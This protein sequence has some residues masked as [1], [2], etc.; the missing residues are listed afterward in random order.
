MGLQ[1]NFCDVRTAFEG[2]VWLSKW[3]WWLRGHR[4]SRLIPFSQMVVQACRAFRPSWI[5]SVGTAPVE[6]KALEAIGQMQ[7]VRLN[8]LTD[9]PWNPTHRAE[10]FM[11]ALPLYDRIYSTRRANLAKL[12]HLNHPQVHH[13]PF[14]YAPEIHFPE[15]PADSER[16][17]LS[18]EVLFVG[19]ADSD[20]LPWI[21]ALIRSGFRPALYGGYWGRFP[22]TRPY[23]KGY[24]DPQRLRRAVGQ[25]KVNL[26]LVRRANRDGHCMRSFEIPAMGG[27]MLTE[28]TEEHREIFGEE[29][30]TVSY[31]R[32][33]HQMIEKLR[34]LLKREDERKRLASAVHRLITGGRNTY[35]DRLE[36]LLATEHEKW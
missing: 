35:R 20:R 30:K 11:E 19:G 14:A 22:E 17:Q 2:S 15:L 16:E 4:P 5:L 12:R 24:A 31:F 36:V 32:T 29:G 21:K 10:W 1:V 27:C 3:N 33:T 18:C 34:W 26:C 13:L 23:A 28:D 9:D 25:A 8:Y 7:I 6:T